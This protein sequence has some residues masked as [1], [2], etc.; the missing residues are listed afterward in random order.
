MPES[1]P[2]ITR[3]VVDDM[4]VASLRFL[5]KMEEADEHLDQLRQ[6]VGPLVNGPPLILRHYGGNPVDG[7][8][9][10]VALPV[11]QP[12]DLGKIKSRVLQGDK[13]CRFAIY[14]PAG[15]R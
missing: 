2:R 9:I 5:G 4:L 12:V 7:A 10:E 6:A 1:N 3:K 11:R 13:F 14:L 8:D 15:T